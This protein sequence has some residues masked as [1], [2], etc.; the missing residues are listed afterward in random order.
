MTSYIEAKNLSKN[1]ETI[2]AVKD[3]SLR[4]EQGEVLG[5]LGPNGAGKSTTMKM[6]TGYLRPSSGSV[7]IAGVDILQNPIAAQRH[8]G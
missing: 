2:K 1:F 4:V 7:S 6:I 3:I 5:F 8:I